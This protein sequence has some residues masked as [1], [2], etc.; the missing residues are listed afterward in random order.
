LSSVVIDDPGFGQPK[1]P[2]QKGA[3]MV[4]FLESTSNGQRYLLDDIFSIRNGSNRC[5]DV[6]P[7][8]RLAREPMP[9]HLFANFCCRIIFHAMNTDP[10]RRLLAQF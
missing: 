6:S 10:G 9:S 5:G 8:R 2:G 3:L 7:D 4:V 1:G